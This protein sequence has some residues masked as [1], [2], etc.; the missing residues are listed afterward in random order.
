MTDKEKKELENIGR[1]LKQLLLSNVNNI[2][3]DRIAELLKRSKVL[4]GK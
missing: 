2:H 4:K 3:K 1:E